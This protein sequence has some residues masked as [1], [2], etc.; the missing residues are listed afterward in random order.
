MKIALRLGLLSAA[1]LVFLTL[2]SSAYKGYF[3]DDG[4]DNAVWTPVP[5][6]TAYA[7]AFFSP[8]YSLGNVRAVGHFFVRVLSKTYNLDFPKWV[9]WIHV[10]HFANVVLIWLLARRLGAGVAASS[11]GVAFFLVHAAIVEAVWQPMYV[12]DQLCALFCILSLLLYRHQR[13]VLSFVAFWFAYKSKE[14]AIM[15]PIVL[16][17]I[18]FW[19]GGRKWWRLIPF[20]LVSLS[21]GIQGI[22]AN[23][24]TPR[25][26]YSLSFAPLDLWKTVSFY[27]SQILLI[28]FAGILILAVPFLVRK[29]NVWLGLVLC[30]TTLALVLILPNRVSGAYLYLPLAGLAIAIAGF[31]EGKALLAVAVAL[32]LWIP[33]NIFQL[34]KRQAVLIQQASANQSY[35]QTLSEA[36]H[37]LP[38]TTTYVVDSHPEQ[39]HFWGI[40]AVLRRNLNKSDE[41]IGLKTVHTEE[42]FHLLLDSNTAHLRWYPGQSRLNIVRRPSGAPLRSF[43]DLNSKDGEW[44]LGEGWHAPSKGARW[45]ETFATAH[46][47]RPNEA[48]EFEITVDVVLEQLRTDGSVRLCLV[49][50]KEIIGNV[51]LDKP[52]RQ[53]LEWPV[54]AGRGGTIRLEFSIQPDYTKLPDAVRPMGIQVSSFG[55]VRK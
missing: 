51:A 19:F 39:F 36:A 18:E 14:P 42:G 13:Y 52:G 41:E 22:L 47:E 9:A 44:Q 43:L 27:S 6:L 46:L 45:A 24:S 12:F 55:F 29:R 1:L 30:V 49:H 4:Y 23:Q 20:F 54:P 26:T 28:P 16:L 33:L 21:F 48:S 11:L 2:N 34:L 8:R 15:L 25:G 3:R 31:A 53:T 7:K 35:V 17:A 37:T 50:D 32:G 5:G 40:Q 10:I 38:P